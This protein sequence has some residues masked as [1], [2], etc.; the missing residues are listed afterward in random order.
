LREAE[1]RLLEFK[2]YID[3]LKGENQTLLETQTLLAKKLQGS[4]KVIHSYDE[5][6]KDLHNENKSLRLKMKKVNLESRSRV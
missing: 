4:E 3:T 1:D 2:D 6:V 5:K